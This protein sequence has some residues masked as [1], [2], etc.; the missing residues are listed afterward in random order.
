MPHSASESHNIPT[1]KATLTGICRFSVQ[2]GGLANNVQ[3]I[4]IRQRGK[5]RQQ[6]HLCDSQTKMYR[7]PARLPLQKLDKEIQIS[8]KITSARALPTA[9]ASVL[10]ASYRMRR[11]LR[12]YMDSA[13]ATVLRMA[14][15]RGSSSGPA[16]SSSVAS[17]LQA[18]SCTCLLLS[19]TRVSSP[20]TCTVCHQQSTTVVNCE[21]APR[22]GQLGRRQTFPSL[23][24]LHGSQG[25]TRTCMFKAFKPCVQCT[26]M[27]HSSCHALAERTET[28]RWWQA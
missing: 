22:L 1:I 11:F 15:S 4:V 3:V 2:S 28:A 25:S 8:G 10:M 14:G 16:T 26:R 13:A 9:S 24:G 5:Y 27:I 18:A 7:F 20:C 19:R 23:E 17:A 12:P 6:D 21:T